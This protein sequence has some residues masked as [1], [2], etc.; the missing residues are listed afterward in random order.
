[1]AS[2][3]T[4][5]G[6]RSGAGALVSTVETHDEQG[7]PIRPLPDGSDIRRATPQDRPRVVEALAEGFCDD[8][9]FA[10]MFRDA[11]RR[12][13]RHR[14]FFDLFVSRV[15]LPGG[16]VYTTDRIAGAAC[17]MPPEKNRITRLDGLRLLPG[18]VAACGRELTRL[19]AVIP[20][21]DH[22]HPK[23]RHWYLAMVAVRPEWRGRGFGAALLRPVLD[24]CDADGV[25]AYLE[26][27]SPRN[28]T[29][30]ERHGFEVRDEIRVKDAPPLWPMWREPGASLAPPASRPAGPGG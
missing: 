27:T 4:G 15:Y 1:L 6:L 30:Y 23:E 12:L 22:V 24:R 8:P 21:I 11:E 20:A 10:W 29:L 3:A 13:D 14:S 5:A 28:R 16:H 7:L 18:M 25:P 9:L 19:G 26:A 17:W 2:A